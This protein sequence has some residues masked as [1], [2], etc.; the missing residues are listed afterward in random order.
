VAQVFSAKLEI[1]EKVAK[2][3][4]SL[5]FDGLDI[6]M[7]CPDK[8]VERQLSG[9]ALIKNPELAVQLIKAAQKG[10]KDAGSEIPVSVKTRVG[11]NKIEIDTWLPTLLSAEPAVVTL[12]ARTRKEMS[13]VPANWDIIKKAVEIR[14]DLKSD[15]LIFG[16]G[17][18]ESVEDA[19]RKALE[20][21][22]DGVM[23]GRGMFGNPWIF[24]GI[25]KNDIPVAE[26]LR[27]MMEHTKLFE[28]KLGEV[29]NFAIMKKHYKAYCDGF[30]GAKELRVKL[31]EA[32]DAREVEQIVTNF[33]S[34]LPNK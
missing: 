3:V 18:V 16:N 10:V 19:K 1:M 28:E 26:R 31:M 13:K 32:K 9:A 14:D 15:T 30:D 25:N 8:G 29:K 27:V 34:N 6:N 23:I 33:L 5:G 21:G 17:D 7:G 2:L 11:Y 4:V 20:S 12:H 24:A 22:C